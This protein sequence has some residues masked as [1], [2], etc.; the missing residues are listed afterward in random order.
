MSHMTIAMEE[1]MFMNHVYKIPPGI[2]FNIK[3]C[4]I[5]LVRMTRFW[6]HPHKACSKSKDWNAKVT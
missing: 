2:T 3:K 1:R 5:T 6:S 4:K